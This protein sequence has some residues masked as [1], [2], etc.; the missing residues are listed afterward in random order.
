MT[1]SV[2]TFS[3][4]FF[5]SNMKRLKS[6]I[7]PNAGIDPPVIGNVVAVVAAGAWIEREQPQGCHAKIHGDSQASV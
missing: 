1:S 4:R 3:P 6:A 5:A 7:V 2:M